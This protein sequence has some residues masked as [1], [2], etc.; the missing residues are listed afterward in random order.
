MGLQD[1]SQ[2]LQI[3]EKFSKNEYKYD[4]RINRIIESNRT[5]LKNKTKDLNKILNRNILKI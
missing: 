3:T 5:L 4:D 2:L 1:L